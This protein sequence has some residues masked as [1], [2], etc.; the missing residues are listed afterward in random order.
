MKPNKSL[1]APHL[2]PLVLVGAACWMV[3]VQ[4]CSQQLR[5]GPGSGLED[6]PSSKVERKYLAPVSKEILRVQLPVAVEAT[7]ANGL[8]VLILED[9]R[10]P[11]V[12]ARLYVGGAGSL[13]DPANLPGLAVVT[14]EMLLEGTKSRTSRKIAEEVERLGAHLSASAGF[15][16]EATTINAS[17]LS[18]NFDEWFALAADVLLQPVFP[19][20]ELERLKQRLK[21]Q[22]R[23][24]RASPSFLSGER[25]NRAVFGSHP[26]AVVSSTAEAIDA[27]TRAQLTQWHRERYLPQNA[28]LGIAGDV[29]AADL[30]PKLNRWLEGWHRTG[31]KAILPP[32]PAPAKARSE[33]RRVG[34]ECRL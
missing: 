33:E 32:A 17:G 28:I 8:T 24:Q 31:A 27:L 9:R 6:S 20:E 14:A 2:R 3:F 4:A 13:Y 21:T 18:D 5:A 29:R 25:F 23:Q 16:G 30:I 11:T 15:G 10:L 26:A 1:P 12:S 34:K 7:L 19:A 22:L